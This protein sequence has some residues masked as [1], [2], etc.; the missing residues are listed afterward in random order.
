M[1]DHEA[2]RR[3]LSGEINPTE[4]EDD[5]GLYVMAERIYGSEALE[6]MGISAPEIATLSEPRETVPISSDVSLP[7]FVPEMLDSKSSE[8]NTKGSRRYMLML[9]GLLGMFGVGYNMVFGFGTIL[10]STG[11]ANMREIC[12]DDWGQTKVV[13]TKGYSYDGLHHIDSWVKPM[14][15]PLLGDVGLLALFLIITL[16][17]FILRKKSVHPSNV[18]PL[19]S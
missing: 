13:W 5:A 14:S 10:C 2:V 16:M 15:D 12:N 1:P 19:S 18:L 9:S 3:L 17:G 4:I 6:E 11:I 7:E 8:D